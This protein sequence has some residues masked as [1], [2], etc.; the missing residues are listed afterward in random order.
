MTARRRRRRRRRRHADEAP[1]AEDS[2]TGGNDD[3]VGET[4]TRDVGPRV[5]TYRP[6]GIT[7]AMMM[8]MMMAG[9]PSSSPGRRRRYGGGPIGRRE[10]DVRASMI[11]R[12][13]GGAAD[14][15]RH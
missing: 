9:V 15:G 1:H 2:G 14:G 4:R 7:A 3:G 13:A 10:E 8:M 12:Y 6:D 11:V 5:R